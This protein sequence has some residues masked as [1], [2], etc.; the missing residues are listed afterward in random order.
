MRNGLLAV[1]LLCLVAGCDL[2]SFMGPPS[3]MPA[4][5]PPGVAFGSLENQLSDIDAQ[6]KD[7]PNDIN[8]LKTKAILLQSL[9]YQKTQSGDRPSG[10]ADYEESAKLWKTVKAA[11]P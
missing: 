1:A 2:Q 5:A 11:T 4:T 8:L 3:R 9:A 7:N 6:L 10:Y